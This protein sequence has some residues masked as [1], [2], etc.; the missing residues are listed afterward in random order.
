MART[1]SNDDD[2]SDPRRVELILHGIAAAIDPRS[3]EELPLGKI[4]PED[5]DIEIS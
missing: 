4:E 2:I 1:L 5:I 3:N